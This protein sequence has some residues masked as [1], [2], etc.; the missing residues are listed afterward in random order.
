MC[1]PNAYAV[2]EQDT[3]VRRSTHLSRY[4]RR[5]LTAQPEL[6]PPESISQ[7]FTAADMRERLAGVTGDEA[8]MHALRDLRKRVMLRII[9]RDLGGLATLE[10]V[11]STIT[12]LADIAISTAVEHLQR[13]FSGRYGEPLGEESGG[14][15][16]LHVIGMGK[17]G[18]G[19]L[20]V[21]SDIDLVFAYPED[22]ETR[23]ARPIANGE[24][25]E[26]L[27]RRVIGALHQQTADGYVFRVDMRLRPYGDA[28]PLCAS[29][30]ALEQYLV[31]QGRSWERY[32][33]L[34]ARPLT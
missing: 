34:K 19:E 21:S 14:V 3:A 24:F 7:P 6:L 29:F 25:F 13:E 12:S 17:L 20:N 30:A 5:L 32:A 23:A 10:E 11:M 31:T 15:Q 18:G 27:G 33:W 26:R 2:A 16:T 1:P 8:L 9:A 4:A 22:G 28:G